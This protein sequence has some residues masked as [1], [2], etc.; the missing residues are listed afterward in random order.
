MR[1]YGFKYGDQGEKIVRFV[2]EGEFGQT[3]VLQKMCSSII[4]HK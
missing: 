2:L 3:E 4:I 1:K